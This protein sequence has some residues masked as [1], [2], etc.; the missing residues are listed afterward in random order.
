MITLGI[1]DDFCGFWWLWWILP[2]LLG[3]LLGWAIWAHWRKKYDALMDDYNSLKSQLKST[4]DDLAACR[5]KGTELENEISLLK[6]RI[7]EKDSE[8]NRLNSDLADYIDSKSKADKSNVASGL[9]NVSTK[10]S[11]SKKANIDATTKTATEN[12]TSGLTSAAG[13]DSTSKSGD[14]SNRSTSGKYAKLK[15]G[16]HQIIEGIGPKMESVLHE[17]GVTSW[18]ILAS[19]SPSDLKGIL[20]KYGDKYK[21]I[22]P[23]DWALQAG[24]A[25]DGNWEGLIANQK[26][27]GS[28]SKAEKLMVKL[29]IIRKY[30][31]NDLKAIEGIGPKTAE[32]LTS[33]GIDTWEALANS[34]VDKI[35]GILDQAGAKFKLADPGSWPRQARLAADGKFDE[36]TALQDELDGGK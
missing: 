33:S 14:S 1:F 3:L 23:S 24:F 9:T 27:D 34:S 25:K 20:D 5:K 21:I 16:N 17:N 6:G 30:D 19:K 29:G 10:D 36:L 31:S 32:L 15:D 7:R 35:Q 11:S 22:D 12:I 26:E 4:E 18:S 13:S 2:F 8:I 28:D